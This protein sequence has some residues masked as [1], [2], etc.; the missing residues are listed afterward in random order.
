[1]FPPYPSSTSPILGVPSP[2][3]SPP[4][5]AHQNTPHPT[6]QYCTTMS[7]PSYSLNTASMPGIARRTIQQPGEQYFTMS[8]APL[9]AFDMV[10]QSSMISPDHELTV[11]GR[12][13]HHHSN[14]SSLKSTTTSSSKQTSR[15]VI[16]RPIQTGFPGS[17]TL[18]NLGDRNLA[19]PSRTHIVNSQNGDTATRPFAFADDLS[20]HVANRSI[21]ATVNSGGVSFGSEAAS[22]HSSS[23]YKHHTQL[24]GA[25]IENAARSR[26]PTAE[27]VIPMVPENAPSPQSTY[28]HLPAI[29]MNQYLGYSSHN[30]P[31]LHS[32][33]YRI[34]VTGDNF[35]PFGSLQMPH[36]PQHTPNTDLAP[37]NAYHKSFTRDFWTQHGSQPAGPPYQQALSMAP[38]PSTHPQQ[39]LT[40]RNHSRPDPEHRRRTYAQETHS[41][42]SIAFFCDWLHEDD[43]LCAFQGSLD[44]LKNHFTSSHLSGAQSALGRCH[45][46][47]CL[48]ENDMRR[49]STWRHVRETH[50]RIKRGT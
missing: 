34:T 22:A 17:S 3:C 25:M 19:P 50:L 2:H 9:S 5:Q 12:P 43:T 28:T 14:T 36:L 44:D 6:Q 49:D 11:S 16:T 24:N 10:S 33:Q 41:S 38:S 42:P 8:M 15:T 23:T 20:S 29:N 4:G 7:P 35:P 48:N 37:P 46:Q 32:S 39:D 31:S 27:S 30:P 26:F 21:E 1:M 18:S 40:H 47:G 13:N 45:W